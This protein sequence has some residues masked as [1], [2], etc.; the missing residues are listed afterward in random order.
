MYFKYRNTYLKNTK[1]KNNNIRKCLSRKN[2]I[3]L[4]Q[5]D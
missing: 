2:T 4:T 5:V 1:T 3:I